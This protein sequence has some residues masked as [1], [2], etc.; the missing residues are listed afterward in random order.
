MAE[1][2]DERWVGKESRVERGELLWLMVRDRFAGSMSMSLKHR[3]DLVVR[4][5]RPQGNKELGKTKSAL[6]KGFKGNLW[7]TCS[8]SVFVFIHQLVTSPLCFVYYSLL[9]L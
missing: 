6:A 9:L 3:G 4:Q 1:R 2:I 7:C 5:V 8:M